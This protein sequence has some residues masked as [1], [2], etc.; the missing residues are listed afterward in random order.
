[1]EIIVQLVAVVA[2]VGIGL[3]IARG[4]VA[5]LLRITFGR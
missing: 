2:S 1:V 5:G 4:L 3:L